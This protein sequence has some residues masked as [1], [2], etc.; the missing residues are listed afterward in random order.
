MK[1]LLKLLPLCFVIICTQIQAQTPQGCDITAIRSAFLAAGHY[2]ELS[3][4]GQPCSL[5]FIDETPNDAAAAEGLASQLGAHLVVMNDATEN[6]NVVA[7]INAAG[8]LSNNQFVWIGYHRTGTGASTFYALDGS[9]GAFTPGPAT[10]SLFQNWSGGEPNNNN[11]NCALCLCGS[12]I[13]ANGEQCVQIYSNGLWNDED[14]SDNGSKSVI[15][16]N[17]CPVLTSTS[18][19]TI[20]TGGKVR[21]YASMLLGSSPYT[22]SWQPGNL[23]GPVHNEFPTLPTTYSLTAT[24]RYGCSAT[25]SADVSINANCN[26]PPLPQGCDIAAIRNAFASAGHYTEL[27]VQGQDCSMYFMDENAN[28]AAG[29][30][31]LANAL[32]AHLVVMN[33]ATENANVVAAVNAA[34]YLSNGQAVWVGYHRTGTAASTFYTL[35]GSTGPFT[36]GPSTP[37]LFQNWSGGEPNNS[38]YSNCCNFLCDYT[39]CNGEQCVQIYASGFW[40]D[41]SCD[42]SGNKSIIEVNLCP[43]LRISNDTVVCNPNTVTITTSAIH[44]SLPYSYQWTPGGQTGSSITVT[45]T[46]TSTYKVR[47]TDRYSCRRDDSTVV[48][49]IPVDSPMITVSSVS[50]CIDEIDTVNLIGTYNPSASLNWYFDGASFLGGSATLPYYVSWSQTGSHVISIF[51]TDDVCTSAQ[52]YVSI[53][54]HPDPIPDAGPDVAFCS[55]SS[56]TLGGVV[57]AGETYSWSP[58]T[59]LNN[60][61]ALNS[62]LTLNNPTASDLVSNYSVTV[63]S[64]EGCT[65]TD[66]A[67]VTVHPRSVTTFVMDKDTACVGE[68]VTITYTGTNSPSATYNWN[69]GG[70]TIVSG[71]GQGPYVVTWTTS[72]FPQVSLNVAESGCWGLPTVQTVSVGFPPNPDAGNDTTVC[73]GGTLQIGA[74]PVAGFDYQWSPSTMLDNATSASPNFSYWNTTSAAQTYSLTVVSNQNGCTASDV[75]NVTVDAPALT[76]ILPQSSTSFCDGYSVVLTS[77]NPNVISYEWQPG[78]EI[79]QS[80]TVTQ[81]GQFYMV[82]RD[83]QDCYYESNTI[84]TTWLANPVVALAPN[85]LQNES[86]VDYNDGSITLVTTGGQAPYNYNWNTGHVGNPITNL[87]DGIYRVTVTDQMGCVDSAEYSIVPAVDFY[88]YVDSVLNISCYGLSD[89]AIYTSSTG[90]SPPYSFNWSNGLHGKQL[91]MLPVGTY[92]LTATDAHGCIHDSTF[93]LTQPED[94]L[95]SAAV[96]DS[97]IPYGGQTHIEATVSPSSSYSYFWTPESSLNCGNCED[98]DAFPVRTTSYILVI[99]DNNTKCYDTVKVIIAVDATKRIYI[100]NAF[101]PNTDSRNDTWQVFTGNVK[102]FHVQIYNRWGEQL[103]ESYD[104]NTGWDGRYKGNLVSPGVYTYTLN[105]LYLDNDEIKQSG[106]ITVLR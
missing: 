75:I 22:Y 39:D 74:A 13:C 30:E 72:G 50:L 25:A 97:V 56:V 40:N 41:L 90:G 61:T 69:F 5:Y 85:G 100:P 73:S 3:V 95:L 46:T 26:A 65:A 54:V 35:D 60:P 23:T 44:G 98:P 9:T 48:T 62:V 92:T 83:A 17:L 80:I 36:P 37:Y 8:Y 12:Y 89:G 104:I 87:W 16:V 34:G 55:D 67:Q 78:G 27:D 20:C 51:V 71:S 79:T 28:D 59:G 99:Q 11:Y 43:D 6:A 103:F 88:F 91:L 1:K 81:T 57:V 101:S 86:C 106:T 63:T 82:G 76:S 94:I 2:T 33:D 21:L 96:L 58:V 42:E 102:Y 64:S 77:S 19:T 52:T 66:T 47:L 14:C 18:D 68:N 32:G 38:G 93:T 53:M 70:A 105:L 49:V 24:D 84:F 45:P 7:A 15:E 29:A 4:P 31:S 10:P